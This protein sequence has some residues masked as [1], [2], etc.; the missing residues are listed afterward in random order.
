M[1]EALLAVSGL[2]KTFVRRRGWRSERIPALRDVSFSV[3][4]GE[5]LALVGES[6]SGKS[7]AARIIARLIA[8]SAGQLLY[9]GR[10]VLGEG[11]SLA[12]RARVQM[13][14]QDPFASLNPVHTVGYHLERPLRRHKKPA[15]RA[16]I[17]ALL[18][19]VGL[20]PAAEF[21]R[22][23]PHQLSGGQR[24]RVAVVRALAVDPELLVADE[25]V[26]MLDLSVRIEILN[27]LRGLKER[28]GLAYLYITHDL[29]SARYFADRAVVLYA[30][31]VVESAPIAALLDQPS[32]PYTQLLVAAAPGAPVPAA[33]SRA[34]PPAGCAFAGRCP[35][36]TDRCRREAPE[37]LALG[38]GRLV[39]CHLY[40]GCP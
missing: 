22:R 33:P 31:Q 2:S 27:L 20:R 38:S 7:T 34:A 15:D 17:E 9:R 19:A 35:S 39:R 21:A 32:H 28:R 40:D 5:V 10:D 6:G 13:I 30:G 3:A 4:P 29:G 12:Y 25:P 18:E 14:F 1:S 36:A 23:F 8:P 11:P 26:S 16:Q 24:Q 37:L